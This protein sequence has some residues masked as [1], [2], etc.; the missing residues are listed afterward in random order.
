[1]AGWDKKPD[2]FADLLREEVAKQQRAF[3]VT[4]L[5]YIVSRSPVDTGRYRGS[6]ILS[7]GKADYSVRD[8]ADK[9]GAQTLSLGVTAL[10][11]VRADAL[12]NVYIQTNL[13]YAARLENGWSKQA[14][15]GVY[16]VSFNN[17]VQ[18][19]S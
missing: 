3:A 5:N 13:P 6:H 17:A 10:K 1:M 19:Y 8:F 9:T 14:A 2:L 18:A 16:A 11:G 15:A 4:C 7:V 12:G